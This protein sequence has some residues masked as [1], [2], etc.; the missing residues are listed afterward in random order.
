MKIH[1]KLKSPIYLILLFIGL[2]LFNSCKEKEAEAVAE[3]PQ[4]IEKDIIFG[5]NAY[6]FAD[7]IRRKIQEF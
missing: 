1:S 3:Q 6:S 5:L 4:E 7:L 2:S